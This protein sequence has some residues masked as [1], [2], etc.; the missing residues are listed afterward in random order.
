MK[1]KVASLNPSKIE[2]VQ[3]QLLAYDFLKAAEITGAETS[4]GVAEQPSSLEETVRGAITRAKNAYHDCDY[5]FGIE[6][7]LMTVPYSTSGFMDMCVCAIFDGTQTYL[8]ISSAWELPPDIRQLIEQEKLDMNQAAFKAG[9]TTNPK[10]G[11]AEGLIGILTKGR[12]D[13]KAY[14]KQAILTALIQIEKNNEIQ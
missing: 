7:G 8:G 6:S 12:M 5:S 4:S 11:S 9:Y 3:E 13:R 2:A 14:T 10:V 1:I